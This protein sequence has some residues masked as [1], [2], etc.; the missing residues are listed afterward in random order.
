MV[1]SLLTLML[2]SMGSFLTNEPSGTTTHSPVRAETIISVDDLANSSACDFVY[3]FDIQALFGI[4]T[5]VVGEERIRVELLST[6]S[7]RWHNATS[8][9]TEHLEL[10]LEVNPES[11]GSADKFTKDLESKLNTGELRHPMK[12]Q[13]GRFTYEEIEGP[14]D[15]TIWCSESRALRWH[16]KDDFY[17][18][19]NLDEKVSPR[20]ADEDLEKMI[21]L[22]SQINQRMGL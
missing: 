21:A 5:D 14:G 18:I 13:K 8:G 16:L 3:G 15:L 2:V 7:Y 17:F 10:W 6:C 20:T 22:A 19:M 9:V 4:E 1:S 11:H 12:P